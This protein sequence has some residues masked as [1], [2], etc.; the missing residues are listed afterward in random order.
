M[1]KLPFFIL[2]VLEKY[3]DEN[4]ILT[5]KDILKYL[6]DDHMI[7]AERKAVSANIKMLEE[8]GFD[9]VK[10]P[11]GVFLASRVF[12]HNQ[13]K[14]LIDAIFS[15]K[16]IN[17][18]NAQELVEKITKY[19]SIYDKESYKYLYKTKDIN[20]NKYSNIFYNM[21]IINEAKSLNKRVEFTMITYDEY[22]H[23]ISRN[24]GY[25]YKVSPYY[26]INNY[27]NYYLLGYYRSKYGPF[28]IFRV[29]RMENIKVSDWEAKSMKDAGMPNDF[30]ISKFINEHI[31]ILSSEVV[32]ATLEI[33]DKDEIINVKDYFGTNAKITYED[34]TIYANVR[35]D[36][37]ALMYWIMQ[38]GVNIKVVS[39]DSLKEKVVDN[40]K[41][42]LKLYEE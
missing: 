26:L 36:E 31:Y 4:H 29:D 13:V 10:R 24:D 22:G 17:P 37:L 34:G 3:S 7:D 28:N 16:T 8:L 38:Y 18:T 41:K 23:K 5:Q 15:S 11:K 35:C 39:P 1:K 20:R 19:E 6:Y 2:D 9:I 30:S 14:Y 27:G 42:I 25:S 33:L 21:E 40:L 32:D 12:E